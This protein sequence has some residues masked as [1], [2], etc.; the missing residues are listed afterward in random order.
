[1]IVF[2]LS[3]LPFPF[4]LF[5]FAFSL[6]PFVKPIYPIAR[7][8]NLAED[9]HGLRVAD[10]Y[11]WLED[12]V[13][14]ET[15]AWVEAQNALTRSSLQG[16]VRNALVKRLTELYDFPR[17]NV[18]FKRGRHYFYTHNTGLQDQPVLY[19]QEAPDGPRRVLIDP[20]AMN[21]DGPVA[22]TALA[23]NEAGT[24]AAYGLSQS[25]S[26]RQ[27]IFLRDV[28]TGVDRPDRLHWVKFASIAWVRDGSGFYY[29]RFPE[30]GTV[31]PGDENYFN[32]V[33]YHRLGGP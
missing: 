6:V 9:Y 16:P 12:P 26:D 8:S 2:P 19:V 24:L 32:T 7:K 31:A 13:N 30:P 21:A 28:E 14:M 10:P 33:H 4:C 25:G 3:L 18:P 22:L 20:N 5:P 27:E 1:M 23:V 29:T 17:T 15:V 11:R